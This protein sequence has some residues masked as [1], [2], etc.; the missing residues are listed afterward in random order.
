[1]DF[2]FQGSPPAQAIAAAARR[3]VT[4]MDV[5]LIKRSFHWDIPTTG[6][7]TANC[8]EQH[9]VCESRKYLGGVPESIRAIEESACREI[10]VRGFCVQ[11]RFDPRTALGRVSL[12]G[13]RMMPCSVIMAVM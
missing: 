2:V 11:E 10:A 12:N 6:N 9:G 1:M 4:A 13:A 7:C 3:A 5:F 8:D